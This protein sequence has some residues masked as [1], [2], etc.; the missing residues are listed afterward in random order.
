M[1]CSFFKIE[2]DMGVCS[3]SSDSHIPGIDEMGNL[4]FK[5]V[6]FTCPIFRDCAEDI[7]L[8]VIKSSNGDYLHAL[9]IGSVPKH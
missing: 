1:S 7:D 6:Y 5:D 8:Q 3:A 9:Q 4:C 2:N